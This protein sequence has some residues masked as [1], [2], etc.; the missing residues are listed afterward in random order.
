LFWTVPL[1]SGDDD[2]DGGRA[3]SQDGDEWQGVT[4]DLGDGKARMTAANVHV[5]DFFNIP[6]ALFR[7]QKPVSVASTVSFDIRWMGPATH[8]SAVTK[9]RGSTGRVF[10][11]PV[12]MKWSAISASGFSFKSHA[13][14]TTS[15]FGQLGHVRNGIFGD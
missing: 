6:N 7:F 2:E 10:M 12:A 11:S 8:P 15:F 14:G 3:R 1:R 13:S 5:R 4:V 9:P